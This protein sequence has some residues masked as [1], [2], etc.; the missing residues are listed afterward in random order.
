MR[1]PERRHDR[2]SAAAGKVDVD[3]HH[4]GHGLGDERDR[5]VDVIGLADDLDGVSELGSHPG[6]EHRVVVDDDNSRR[7]CRT[8]HTGCLPGRRGARHRQADLGALTGGA[9]NVRRPT[10]PSDASAN[11]LGEPFAIGRDR[12][13]DRSPVPRSRTNSVTLAGSTSQKIEM[14]GAPDHFA[15]LT[16]ASRAAPS[17][18]MRSSSSAQSPTITVSTLTWCCA[19]TSAW[20]RR[21]PAAS[22]V[23]LVAE[24]AGRPCRR[25]ARTEVRAPARGRAG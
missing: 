7:L 9:A 13:G 19:S 18:A 6:A 24:R 21:T 23:E 10:V 16:V 22:V 25:R 5:R 2:V 4:I 14:T 17:S 3:E 8:G 12:V 11:R 20:I 15:A 1:R